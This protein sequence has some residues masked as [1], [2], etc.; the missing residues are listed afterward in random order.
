MELKI[1]LGSFIITAV[2]F[3]LFCS[4]KEENKDWKLQAIKSLSAFVG[5]VVGITLV[6]MTFITLL[7][8]VFPKLM[9]SPTNSDSSYECER[10]PLFGGCN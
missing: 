7:S 9:N 6:W 10:D 3:I 1:W 4:I 2:S 8:F 5:C